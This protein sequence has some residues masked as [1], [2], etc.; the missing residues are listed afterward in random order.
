MKL[1]DAELDAL[2]QKTKKNPEIVQLYKDHNFL[3]A[4]A[5]H[6]DYRVAL[7]PKGAIGNHEEWDKYGDIQRDFLVAQGLKSKHS[8]L[9]IGC[10]TGRLARKVVPYLESGKY[11]GIDLSTQA[12]RYAV[13]ISDSE[14]WSNKDPA[15]Y[16]G[17]YLGSERFDF[18]WAF[19]V[20][21]HL[22]GEVVRAVIGQAAKLMH[23]N[24]KFMFSY[25]PEKVQERTGLKQFRAT[26]EFYTDAA[27]SAGFSFRE[28]KWP[29][30]QR[31]ALCTLE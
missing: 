19:S 10:G 11:T 20:F 23:A 9:D 2:P 5:L 22:P 12:I 31:I 14:G 7:N 29:G 18:I 1:T 26:L 3:E 25:V 17:S 27:T 24:S 15:F 4:Y 6:T 8:L 16:V 21:I 28:V 13:E 30:A